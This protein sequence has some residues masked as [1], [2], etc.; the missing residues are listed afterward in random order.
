MAGGRVYFGN[1][2]LVLS[3][4]QR[5]TF[6]SAGLLELPNAVEASEVHRMHDDVWGFLAR[7]HAVDGNDRSSWTNQRPTGF[8]PLTR[9]GAMNALWAPTVCDVLAE[10]LGPEEQQDRETVRILMTFPQPDTWTVPASGWHFD[11]TPLLPMVELRAAQVFALL[12]DVGPRGGGTLV[13]AGSH[14]L[15]SHY[16]AQTGRSPK[17][18]DVKRALGLEHPWLAELWGREPSDSS[19]DR[20]TRFLDQ[21]VVLDGVEVCV[22]EVTGQAGDVFVM[23]SDCFHAI[24]T[25]ARSDPRLMST[26][27]IRIRPGRAGTND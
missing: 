24:A 25:N 21:P 19:E 1:I 13:L 8:Q 22:T 5:A 4:D 16:V 15:V 11:Y 18:R 9:S 3:P 26:S 12:G 27:L 23:H 2:L 14:R 17:P 20:V 6:E 10:L 7:T